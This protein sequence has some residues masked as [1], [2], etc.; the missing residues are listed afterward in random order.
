MRLR[1]GFARDRI[2]AVAAI[3]ALDCSPDRTTVPDDRLRPPD[4]PA[5]DFANLTPTPVLLG[6]PAFFLAT[7]PIL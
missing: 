5:A 4:G 6:K 3:A 2:L 7:A 1:L